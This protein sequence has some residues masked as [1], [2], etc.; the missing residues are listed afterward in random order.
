[1][2]V[3]DRVYRILVM[4]DRSAVRAATV[5]IWAA[6]ERSGLTW[7]FFLLAWRT[8]YWIPLFV[9]SAYMAAREGGPASYALLGRAMVRGESSRRKSRRLWADS[10]MEW[11]DGLFRSYALEALIKRKRLG[12]VR[13]TAVAFAVT[14]SFLVFFD[15]GRLDELGNGVWGILYL[16]CL[17]PVGGWIEAAMPPPPGT[18]KREPAAVPDFA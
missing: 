4:G 3:G 6:A 14:M 16:S 11:D 1:M 2:E 5:A 12:W 17:T 9:L 15:V 8:A 18:G 7:P 13:I 10:R